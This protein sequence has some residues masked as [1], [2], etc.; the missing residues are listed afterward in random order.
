MRARLRAP[1]AAAPD[2][3]R[4]LPLWQ[5]CPLVRAGRVSATGETTHDHREQ[6]HDL[7]PNAPDQTIGTPAPWCAAPSTTF[8]TC[9]RAGK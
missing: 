8:L 9:G 7:S 1:A 5:T 3:W 6:V 4:A 2:W